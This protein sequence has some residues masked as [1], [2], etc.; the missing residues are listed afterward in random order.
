MQ[1]DIL[2][3]EEDLA[4][5]HSLTATVLWNDVLDVQLFAEVYVETKNITSR[6][7]TVIRVTYHLLFTK[8]KY[9]NQRY[10]YIRHCNKELFIILNKRKP[11]FSGH[12]RDLRLLKLQEEIFEICCAIR[13]L[14]TFQSPRIRTINRKLRLTILAHMVTSAGR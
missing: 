13:L 3:V 4:Q 7:R 14:N 9:S 11:A 12:L 1:F 10:V 5:D 8:K 2:L 6:V